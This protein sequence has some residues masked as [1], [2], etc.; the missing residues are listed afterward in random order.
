MLLTSGTFFRA[1]LVLI[2]PTQLSQVRTTTAHVVYVEKVATK[3]LTTIFLC[4]HCFLVHMYIDV[5]QCVTSN[6][7]WWL[8]ISAV[9][10]GNSSWPFLLQC[11]AEL[12]GWKCEFILLV[13]TLKGFTKVTE[14]CKRKKIN[15]S[16]CQ[17]YK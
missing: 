10:C 14:N 8:C 9:Y 4:K 2:V 1:P 6:G 11:T 17:T 5:K 7:C 12:R 3:C 13:F 15:S 16:T